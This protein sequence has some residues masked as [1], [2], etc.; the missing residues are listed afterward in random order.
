MKR[1]IFTLAI[2]MLMAGITLTSCNSSEKKAENAQ[3]KDK[4]IEAKQ[5]LSQVRKDSI[6][7]VIDTERT[8]IENSLL[9]LQKKSIPTTNLRPQI[10]QK[11]SKIDFYTEN[12]QIVRIKSYPYEKISD[13]TEEF[14]FQKGKLML[15][16]IEDEGL[17]Y[18]GK[19]DKRTGKTYYFFEDAVIK[20]I[21]QT[22]EKETSI[23]N[24]DSE[25]LLQEAY[26]Y[27]ELFPKN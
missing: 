18:K 25:R 26:E 21:N 13:R 10:K 22:N 12:D 20:E 23:R 19:S 1:A 7:K 11:W 16:F 15:G 4:V 8:R 2:T 24:S 14:Y 9:S 6:V 17:Q 5:E 27:I 3:D